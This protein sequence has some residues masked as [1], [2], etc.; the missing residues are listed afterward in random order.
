MRISIH[1]HMNG[2]W[3]QSV[4]YET[5]KSLELLSR[6]GEESQVW[7]C[8]IISEWRGM[9]V[10]VEELYGFIF[11]P[12]VRIHGV[13]HQTFTYQGSQPPLRLLAALLC[14]IDAHL[15][16][17]PPDCPASELRT[18]CLT[19]VLCVDFLSTVGSYRLRFTLGCGGCGRYCFYGIF[20]SLSIH[21]WYKRYESSE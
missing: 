7:V 1:Y 3:R 8:V 6:Q 21:L 2:P 9:N 12:G 11:C 18:V 10:W 16:T 15:I 4:V 19:C 20:E 17:H 13:L 5:C 14:I